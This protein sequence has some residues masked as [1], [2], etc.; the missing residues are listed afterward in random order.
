[1]NDY[2]NIK[3]PKGW[4]IKSFDLLCNSI[5]S[6]LSRRLSLV[7]IGLPV[8]NSGN[9]K[10][11]G[12]DLTNLKYWHFDDPQGA[13][14]KDYFL[15]NDDILLNFINS[16]SQIG[17]SAIY[18]D[19]GRPVIFTT[20]IFRIRVKK[21]IL[22]K[23]L[24][25]YMQSQE[26]KKDLKLITKPAVNQA[27]F[28]KEDLA[29]ILIPLPPINEQEKIIKLLTTFNSIINKSKLKLE[30]LKFLKIALREELLSKGLEKEELKNSNLGK[31]P[32]SWEIKKLK[33]I[34]TCIRGLTYSPDDISDNGLLVLRSSNISDGNIVLD[35]LV[36]VSKE[37]K[38]EFISKE[39]DI[40][41]CVRNG[42]RTLLGKSAV[43]SS[44]LPKSTHGAFMTIFRTNEN[45]FVRYLFQSNLFF[46][47]VSRD[48]GATINSINNQNLLDYKFAFPSSEEQKKI[49]LILS[50]I[51]EKII[52]EKEYLIK[53]ENLERSLLEALLTGRK[54]VGI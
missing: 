17:K 24:F 2:R 51:D 20:N 12:L 25:A 28:T 27:S 19:F 8:V 54:R 4:E 35:D 33:E 26:F 49:V 15:E 10:D 9:L 18:S 47:Q 34:G 53:I 31:I 44:N 7:D 43:I 32:K 41:I 39:G 38:S 30:K 13:N 42:S 48:I 46:K 11:N 23:Y 45:H 22:S 5:R 37:L 50:S 21:E 52:K 14:T 3:I 6:G 36:Y 1:M 16:I 29:K 40:L